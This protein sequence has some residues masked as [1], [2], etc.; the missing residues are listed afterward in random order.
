MIKTYHGWLVESEL[1]T[2]R[3]EVLA[4][5]PNTSTELLADLAKDENHWVLVR[6]AK[7]PNTSKETLA[8]LAQNEYWRIRL[9]VVGNPNIQYETLHVLSQ[10]PVDR[11]SMAAKIILTTRQEEEMKSWGWDEDAIDLIR[12]LGI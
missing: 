2:E 8:K 11:V 5:D 6:V 10:D 7:N 3:R 9:A 1:S 4:Q 12:Q